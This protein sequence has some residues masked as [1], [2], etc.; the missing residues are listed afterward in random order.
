MSE[1]FN[2]IPL[3][4]WVLIV[5]WDIIWKMIA[6]WRAAHN[7]QLIWFIVLAVINTVGIL[8]IIYLLMNRKKQSD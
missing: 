6:M 1:I 5:I 4:V 8:P 3:W 2:S 7:K